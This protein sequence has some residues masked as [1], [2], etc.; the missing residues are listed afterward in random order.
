M[1]ITLHNSVER[2]AAYADTLE[3]TG[4]SYNGAQFRTAG[5]A[6]TAC[7][8]AATA[9]FDLLRTQAPANASRSAWLLAGRY[10]A[11]RFLCWPAP[12]GQVVLEFWE[13]P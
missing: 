3:W 2:A 12:S 1:T 9:A 13:T 11:G 5:E 10:H 6:V 8:R 4:C 7:Y